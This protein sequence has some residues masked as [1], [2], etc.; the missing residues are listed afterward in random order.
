MISINVRV[1]VPIISSH[2]ELPAL[3]V[4]TYCYSTSTYLTSYR[5]LQARAQKGEGRRRFIYFLAP[6]NRTSPHQVQAASKV[7]E[8]SDLPLSPV[9][10]SSILLSLI[11]STVDNSRDVDSA[12][13]PAHSEEGEPTSVPSTTGDEAGKVAQAAGPF[14]G[15]ERAQLM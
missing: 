6:S 3:S 8:H 5:K 12:S 1:T 9:S 7:F 13:A 15:E 14:S 11:S 2:L 4:I 10:R